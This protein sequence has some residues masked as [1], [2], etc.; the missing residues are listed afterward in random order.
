MFAGGDIQQQQSVGVRRTTRKFKTGGIVVTAV[1]QAAA[2]DTSGSS[3]V[4]RRMRDT[5]SGHIKYGSPGAT[6]GAANILQQYRNN[7]FVKVNK[8]PAAAISLDTASLVRKVKTKLKKRK[9][10]TL[11][12]AVAN[13]VVK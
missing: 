1:Q 2:Y 9:S 4:S 7:G 13:A 11:G 12:N 5:S 8:K 3:C 10:R 6:D